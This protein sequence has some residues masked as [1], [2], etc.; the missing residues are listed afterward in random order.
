MSLKMLLIVYNIALEDEVT[1][2]MKEQGA[3]CFTQ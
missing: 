2:L 3:P 1:D